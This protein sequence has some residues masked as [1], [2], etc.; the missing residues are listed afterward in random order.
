MIV[1]SYD[2]K[3]ILANYEK[4]YGKVKFGNHESE[5]MFFE[6]M[7]FN[8]G[9]PAGIAQRVVHACKK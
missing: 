6:T 3:K 8:M 9:I 1:T 7:V 2:E 5:A 4:V